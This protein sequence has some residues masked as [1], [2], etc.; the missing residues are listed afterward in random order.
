MYEI[1]IDTM[2]I[3]AEKAPSRWCHITLQ[4]IVENQK[5]EL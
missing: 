5:R 2:R 4:F 3:R 1:K